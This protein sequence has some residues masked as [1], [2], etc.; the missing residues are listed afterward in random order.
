[1][2]P[3]KGQEV[4]MRKVFTIASLAFAAAVQAQSIILDTPLAPKVTT[5]TSGSGTLSS[6]IS[7]TV[8]QNRAPGGEPGLQTG[9]AGSLSYRN[10][11]VDE[12]HIQVYA[13]ADRYFSVGDEPIQIDYANLSYD[14]R[15]VNSGGSLAGPDVT[16]SLNVTGFLYEYVQATRDFWLTGVQSIAFAN[17]LTGNGFAAASGSYD[18]LPKPFILTPGTSY[19]VLVELVDTVSFANTAF[20]PT[21]GVTLEFGQFA[22]TGVQFNLGYAPVPEPATRIAFGLGLGLVAVLRRRKSQG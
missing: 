17:D 16:Q 20:V 5:S 19:L 8:G 15:L 6:S 22:G 4:Q 1:L 14:L 3:G 21:E 11:R 10:A 9:I 13:R 7:Q 12:Q 2:I 18:A